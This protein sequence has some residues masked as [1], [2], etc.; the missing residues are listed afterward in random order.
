MLAEQVTQE[1]ANQLS[2]VGA[3]CQAQ[4]RGSS[5]CS[6]SRTRLRDIPDL[7]YAAWGSLLLNPN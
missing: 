2:K 3:D 5:A 7:M 6:L 4:C 1:V